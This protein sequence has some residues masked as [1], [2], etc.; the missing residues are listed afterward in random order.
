MEPEEF[1]RLRQLARENRTS[2]AELIRSAV[3][4]T[5]LTRQS[6]R[7]AIVESIL[8]VRLPTTPWKK[9]RKEIEAAHAGFP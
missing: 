5:Y 6:D 3:R 1:R 8:Q 9:A 4:T 7:K 2:V